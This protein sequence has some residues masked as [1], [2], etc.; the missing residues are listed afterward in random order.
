MKIAVVGA[1]IAGTA[2][3]EELYKLGYEV[4]VFEESAENEPTRPRQ[5]EGGAFFLQ[6][7]AQIQTDHLMRSVQIHSP[8]INAS[9]EGKLGFFYEVGG[10]NGVEVKARKKIET[11]IPV[12]YS[13]RV[14]NTKKL[15]ENFHA[16]VDAEGYRS[17]IAKEQ[18]FL[19]SPHPRQIG[20][21]IGFTVEGD[22]DPEQMEIWFDGYFAFQGYTY[23]IPF[24]KHEASLVS[25]SIG[26]TINQAT[27]NQRLKELAELKTWKLK[28]RWTDFECWNEFQTYNKD[29]MYLIGNTG[30]FTDPAFGF[31]LKWALKSAKLCAKS[32]N[33]NLNY[34][35]LIQRELIPDFEPFQVMRN[36]FEKA[37]GSDYDKLVKS[38]NK[39]LVKKLAASGKSLLKLY[40]RNRLFAS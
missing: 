26:K 5:M 18:G 10:K 12:H 17:T 1:G 14:E 6:N 4:E 19:V 37:T 24:S 15:Q 20:V 13:T 3:A 23:L 31:G 8:S 32:I 33:E 7:V 30:S 25:A 16:I 38:F 22:F 29:N 35:L 40:V 34:N 36:F 2:C 28:E 9:L 27:Y 21:G 39:F 11:K